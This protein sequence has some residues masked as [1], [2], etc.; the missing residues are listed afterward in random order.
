MAESEVARVVFT[1]SR[2]IYILSSNHN[3]PRCLVLVLYLNDSVPNTTSVTMVSFPAFVLHHLL[4]GWLLDL[5]IN[6]MCMHRGVSDLTL[7]WLSQ[8]CTYSFEFVSECRASKESRETQ[9]GGPRT[10]WGCEP[11]SRVERGLHLGS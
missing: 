3:P 4:V 7:I 5:N 8:N 11:G 2:F 1:M 9:W 10:L 6:V